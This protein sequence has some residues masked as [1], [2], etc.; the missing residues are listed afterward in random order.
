MS[1][2][3]RRIALWFAGTLVLAAIVHFAV[4]LAIPRAIGSYLRSLAESNTIV[5]AAKPSAGNDQVR[6]SS[7]DLVYSACAFDLSD[8]PLRI[9]AP[10]P[11]SYMSVSFYA[12]NTDNFYVQNDLQVDGCFDVV[13]IGPNMPDPGIK[14]AEVVRAPSTTGGILFR[15]FAGDGQQ[16]REI[17]AIRQRIRIRRVADVQEN[18]VHLPAPSD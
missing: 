14:G 13:L 9:T 18:R 8:G 12:I 16:Q 3:S 7:P 1:K 4:V 10:V 6:R 2:R 5:H 11:D 17:E 15:Y